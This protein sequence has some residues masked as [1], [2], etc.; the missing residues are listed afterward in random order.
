MARELAGVDGQL[1]WG[2]QAATDCGSGLF[3]PLGERR[4]A[5]A[6]ARLE[7]SRL[8]PAGSGASIRLIPGVGCAESYA[9]G[10]GARQAAPA[11]PAGGVQFHGPRGTATAQWSRRVRL[12]Q[13][14]RRQIQHALRADAFDPGGADGS[15]GLRTGSGPLALQLT[16]AHP[17]DSSNPTL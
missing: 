2:R 5:S 10:S 14:T 7:A 3:W 12:N 4:F 8:L 13:V 1:L 9:S 17:P 16:S 15:F 11:S 6:S